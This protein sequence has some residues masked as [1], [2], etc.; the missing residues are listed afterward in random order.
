MRASL[1]DGEGFDGLC[2][3]CADRAENEKLTELHENALKVA[4]DWQASPSDAH[5][6]QLWNAAEELMDQGRDIGAETDDLEAA[7]DSGDTG[8]LAAAIRDFTTG[9]D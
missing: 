8:K 4:A 1:D 5:R 7:Y 6:N 9:D 3:N 2:G